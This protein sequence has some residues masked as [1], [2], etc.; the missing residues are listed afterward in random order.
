MGGSGGPGGAGG[1][2]E[3]CGSLLELTDRQITQAVE[4][5]LESTRREG[6][7]RFPAVC[8]L[9]GRGAAAPV[10]HRK[11][12]QFGLLAVVL[13]IVSTLAV[14]YYL[15][16]D[17]ERQEA[18]RQ[19]LERLQSDPHVARNLGTPVTAD[20]PIT[21]QIKSDETGWQEVKLTVPVRGPM[22]RGV[23]EVAGGREGGAW[24]FTTLDVA[25]P[26]VK[27]RLDLVAGRVAV[28][29]PDAF[30]DAHTHAAATPQLMELDVPPPSLDG[31]FPCVVASWGPPGRARMD[32]CA[33]SLPGV[34]P[35]GGPEQRF[36]V[37][38]RFG[39][40]VLHSADL[41]LTDGATPLRFSRTYASQF[42]IHPSRVH[43]FGR[44]SSHGFDVAPVGSRNPYRDQLLVL[45][46]GD[47]LY[48][49]RISKGTGYADAV[50]R[51]SETASPF[52]K[53]T[54]RW[55]SNGWET[56]LEDGSV[57]RFPESYNAQTLA[58]GAAT[59]MTDP[60]GR[61]L[62]LI[63]DPQRNLREIRTA[64]GR[65]IELAPDG[66][67]RIVRA[68]D[69]RGH[70]VAYGYGSD[71]LLTDVRHSDGRAWRYTYAG[72]LLT[73]IHD[74][75]GRLV[76][77]NRYR[78]A[79]IVGQEHP[80]GEQYEFHYRMADNHRYVEEATVSLPDGSRR[81]VRPGDAVPQVLRALPR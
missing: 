47:F 34:G 11:S 74:E 58:Q 60:A 57:I 52:Y 13:L 36:E 67:G 37:D 17:T 6:G 43:A 23:L 28:L 48:F 73:S 79:M 35:T 33:M 7:G 44:N 69:D 3:G 22:A 27:R 26:A 76:L 5:V 9:C 56:R 54:T 24:R 72:D 49:G 1:S 81:S 50:Y 51:H 77:R 21:G 66:Q 64:G 20:G 59:E 2:C 45:P 80:N 46:D 38:L 19:A 31:T 15:G 18:L 65:A 10:S 14:D 63:R 71:G 62:R 70:Q 39:K 8:P 30:A 42:W 12:V 16:R 61:T 53:A 75:R 68:S 32:R 41:A 29:D 25:V 4:D 78:D 40:F 55:D